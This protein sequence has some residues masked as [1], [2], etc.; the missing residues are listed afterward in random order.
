MTDTE[1]S[2]S[3]FRASYNERVLLRV[4][5]RISTPARCFTKGLKTDHC[6]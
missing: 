6:H 4:K 1:A 2:V 3:S 5:L